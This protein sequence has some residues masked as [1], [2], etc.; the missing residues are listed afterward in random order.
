MRR[1]GSATTGVKWFAI[2]GLIA[3]FASPASAQYFGRNKVRYR[4]F[5]FQVMRT[6]HFDIYFY[7]SEREGA[8][9]AAR[10]A[11]RWYERLNRIFSHSLPDRQ[12]LV[13]YASHTDF[14]Q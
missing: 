1:A 3:A 4:T 9:I 2:A 5:D 12:P 14:E 8:E 10:L 11:E 6:D 13:L 7:A